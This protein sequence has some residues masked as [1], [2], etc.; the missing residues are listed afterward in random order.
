MNA[1]RKNRLVLK[2]WRVRAC[3]REQ[4]GVFLRLELPSPFF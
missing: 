4:Y 1:A 3:P 2:E